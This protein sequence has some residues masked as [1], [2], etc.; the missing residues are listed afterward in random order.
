MEVWSG[1]G[2]GPRPCTSAQG[3]SALRLTELHGQQVPAPLL[4]PLPEPYPEAAVVG[5]TP[6]PPTSFRCAGEVQGQPSLPA[7]PTPPLAASRLTRDAPAALSSKA[8]PQAPPL[9]A[10]PG[11]AQSDMHPLHQEAYR[12]L[13]LLQTHSRSRRRSRPTPHAQPAPTTFQISQAWVLRAQPA[14]KAPQPVLG[15][16]PLHAFRGPQVPHRQRNPV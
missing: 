1:E 4:I 14:W 8:R 2:L 15:P 7:A 16:W 5:T 13:L 11:W 9:Q 3:P 12:G 10:P 6:R